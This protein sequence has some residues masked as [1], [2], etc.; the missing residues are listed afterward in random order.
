MPRVRIV[1]TDSFYVLAL[2]GIKGVCWIN[3]VQAVQSNAVHGRWITRFS[4]RSIVLRNAICMCRSAGSGFPV[5]SV[6]K[7]LAITADGW[8]YGSG[9]MRVRIILRIVTS[10]QKIG[11]RRQRVDDRVGG[12]EGGS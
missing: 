2:A 9:S 10:V 3:F 7:R 5:S 4:N 11:C 8:P 12:E 1:P 6:K